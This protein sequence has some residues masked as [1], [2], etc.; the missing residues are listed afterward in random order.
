MK[1][2]KILVIA[3]LAL[4]FSCKPT[5]YT[6]LEK[7]LYAN[8]HTNKGDILLKLE[9]EKVPVTVGNFVSLADGTNTYVTDSL[10]G[11]PYYN[12]VL[13]HRVVKNFV[14]Q[15][16]DPTGTGEGDPGYKF[17]DEF[18]KDENGNLLLKHDRAGILSMA[19]SG[20]STNGSQFFITLRATPKL[21]GKHSVFGSVVKG[22]D[23]VNS[24]VQNDTILEV[25]IVKIGASAKRFN[26]AKAFSD[27]YEVFA[28]KV[29]EASA[30]TKREI[31]AYR[32]KATE[33]PSGLKMYIIETKNGISPK[34]GVKVTVNYAG[35]FT[36][37]KLFDTSFKDVAKAYGV[38]SEVRDKQHGYA[39]F[40]TVYSSEARLIPGFKEGLQ[41]L[42]IGDKAMLF[43]PAHLGYGAQGAG[44]VIPPN[45][46]LVFV[47]ELVDTVSKKQ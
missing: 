20:P 31:E 13:F 1:I 11:K 40:T 22:Q 15:G 2:V 14:I 18:P 12:G 46:D 23:V 21:D 24:I 29:L 19:N 5:K 26:A 17:M 25:E 9:F 3:F 34:K 36:D 47:V 43:I 38:Y 45:T 16:G 39:P 8:M 44:N 37:G 30:K 28:K 7:G 27:G 33:L 32:E 35:Y 4:T 41:Q 42:K 10:K 6:N